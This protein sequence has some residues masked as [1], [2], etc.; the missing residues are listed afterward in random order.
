[1]YT[2]FKEET[3]YI[4]KKTTPS[5]KL[6]SKNQNYSSQKYLKL[7]VNSS[8]PKINKK[9]NNNSHN[10]TC[11]NKVH[12]KTKFSYSNPTIVYE[13]DEIEKKQKQKLNALKINESFKSFQSP[14]KKK[15]YLNLDER[16]QKMTNQLYD[17][18]NE[19]SLVWH[20]N[21]LRKNHSRKFKVI[22]FVN[23]V[24]T[25]GIQPIT[26]ENED[27]N[28][29]YEESNSNNQNERNIEEKN[30]IEESKKLEKEGEISTSENEDLLFPSHKNPLQQNNRKSDIND[31]NKKIEYDKIF[32]KFSEQ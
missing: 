30:E 5:Q 31:P 27:K 22:G 2:S 9:F 25:L 29:N 21:L 1:L 17:K 13:R 7:Y 24:P 11:S 16:H 12:K 14:K 19:Y 26:S 32:P 10:L 23:V 6:R 3:D 18:D 15:N 20:E 28:E 8:K 4:K